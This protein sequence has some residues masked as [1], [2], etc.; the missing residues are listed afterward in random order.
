MD[1]RKPGSYTYDKY[2]FN[3]EPFY[4]GKGKGNR[5]KGHLFNSSLK[6]KSYK[7]NRIK[8]IL[9]DGYNLKDY[10]IKI[11]KNLSEYDAF[12]LEIKMIS[13]IGIDN[14]TNITTG[15]EGQSG[16][17]PWNKGIKQKFDKRNYRLKCKWCNNKFLGNSS[18]QRFCNKCQIKIESIYRNELKILLKEKKYKGVSKSS[19]KQKGKTLSEDHKR[20]ISIAKIGKCLSNKHR[21]NISKSIIN[22]WKKRKEI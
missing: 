20:K 12:N 21:K 17:I 2:H 13:L 16:N 14:L 11:D 22:N 10:I 9:F 6:K 1:P 8:K 3:Y 4:I 18:R 5:W 15:G 19:K 7:N